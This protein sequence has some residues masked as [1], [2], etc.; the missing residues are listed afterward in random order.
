MAKAV[1]QLGDLVKDKVTGFKGIVICQSMW[2]NGCARLMVQP[3][4]LKDG[5]PI[6][7]Q[8]FDDLQLEVL[9]RA[10]V[11]STNRDDPPAVTEPRRKTGGPRPDVSARPHA[12]ARP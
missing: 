2:L 7:P 1:A 10:A 8:T 4:T 12:S 9:S 11:P 6:E 3:T 5:K